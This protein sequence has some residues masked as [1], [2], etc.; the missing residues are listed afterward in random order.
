MNRW[1]LYGVWLLL[2]ALPACVYIPVPER[3][4]VARSRV[5]A[6][7]TAPIRP[8]VS[9]RSDVI[10]LLGGPTLDLPTQRIIAYRWETL[11]GV[12]VW[13]VPAAGGAF[14]VGKL[15]VLL[16]AFDAEDRVVAFETTTQQAWDSL[17]E[18]ALKWAERAGVVEPR[19]P[20]PFVAR[21]VPPGAAL[22]YLYREGGFFDRPDLGLPPPEVRVD[23]KVLGGLRRGEYRVHAVEPG[24]TTITVDPLPAQSLKASLRSAP[25]TSIVIQTLPGQAYYLRVRVRHGLGDMTPVIT[26]CPEAEALPL[27]TDRALAP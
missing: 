5:T 16:V 7:M 27:L 18:H 25:V 15:Y 17:P 26:E 13:A 20:L 21:A 10:A 6:E 4:V 3:P 1:T 19:A 9:T 12:V 2:A 22:L 24:P 11:R 8:G 23:G 14:D